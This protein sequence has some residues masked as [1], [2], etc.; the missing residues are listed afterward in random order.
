MDKTILGATELVGF[1]ELGL[2]VVHARIDT[3]AQTSTI[4]ASHVT[5]QDGRLAAVLFDHSSSLYSGQT[6]YFEHFEP[7]IVVSSNGHKAKRYK[8][9]LLVTIGG[10]HIKVR[11]S[12]ADRSTQVYP[13]L[14]GRD[15]LRGHFIVDVEQ[16]VVDE[17]AGLS[18]QEQLQRLRR[19]SN[20]K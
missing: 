3:G 8:A 1:P 12:L 9:D 16:G 11:F 18:R 7:T 13:V 15:V 20:E 4:W 10:K 17:H 14:I 19:P 6:V 2:D 5:E